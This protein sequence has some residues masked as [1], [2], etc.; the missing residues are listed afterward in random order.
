MRS[1]KAKR[2]RREVGYDA[3]ETTYKHETVGPF[4]KVITKLHP[5]CSRY[6]YQVLKNS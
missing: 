2:L 6:A 3:S 4:R 1:K 5:K